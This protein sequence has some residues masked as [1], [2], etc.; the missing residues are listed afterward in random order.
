MLT[1]EN[2]SYSY[3]GKEM[4]VDAVKKISYTFKE[5]AFYVVMGPSGSGKSTLLHLM[6]AL[7]KPTDGEIR[8]E[9][10]SINV[11]PPDRYRREL[12]T[13]VYQNFCLLPFMT[14]L[15]NVSY[16]AKLQNMSRDAAQKRAAEQLKK[17][18]MDEAY[19]KRLPHTL[20]RGEQQRVAIAR[21]LCAGAKVILADEPTG[22]LDSKNA[23][24]I[25][26][27]FSMLAHTENRTVILVTHDPAVA[28]KA[29]VV[30]RIRDGELAA[31]E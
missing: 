29:D 5:A 17:V 31:Q 24:N 3:I 23:E 12:V 18:D 22:N 27:I 6:D 13:M 2:V 1:L 11:I 30:L 26:D 28:Q 20:S 8:Y 4:R 7:D 21:A 9:G 25:V 14:V 15:E 19:F 16:P 10:K